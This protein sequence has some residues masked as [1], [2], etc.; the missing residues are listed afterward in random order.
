MI[1]ERLQKALNEQVKE[2][3]ASAYLYLSMAAYS[4]AEG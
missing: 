1:G 3:L 2:E 4:A